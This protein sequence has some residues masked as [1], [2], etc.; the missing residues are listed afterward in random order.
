MDRK[1]E[2]PPADENALIAERRAKLARLREAGAAFPNDFRRDALAADLHA[3]YEGLIRDLEGQLA[4]DQGRRLVGARVVQVGADLPAD[5]EQVPEPGARHERGRR[6]LALD[7]GVG[8][9]GG[10]VGQE[11]HGRG[12]GACAGG[13]VSPSRLP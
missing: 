2:S 4:G 8:G 10:P 5:L 3:T 12:P 9:H 1:D 13:T 7:D 11:P 6:A